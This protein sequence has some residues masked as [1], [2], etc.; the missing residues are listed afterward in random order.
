M[1]VRPLHRKAILDEVADRIAAVQVSRPRV[2]LDGP[3]PTA[4]ASW[5]T[6]LGGVLEVR[7]RPVLLV[8]AADFLRPASLR[9]ERGRTDPDAYLDDRLDTG[10]LH[11]EL[12]EPLTDFGDGR[13]LSRWWDPVTDRSARA[14]YVTVPPG[15]VVVLYGGLLLRPGIDADLRIHLHL[16]A[17]ALSRRLDPELRWTLP[18][19]D[20]YDREVRP[21]D[22]ADI[23][24]LLDDPRRPAVVTSP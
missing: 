8:D 18:A 3:P 24:V 19:W 23:T 6:D 12:L 4:P 2:L 16:S 9:L 21:A 14:D 22:T 7:G 13:V 20:R 1:R 10:A 17:A 11:R 15:G 5:A